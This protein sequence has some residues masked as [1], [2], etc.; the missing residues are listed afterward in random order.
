MRRLAKTSSQTRENLAKAV[1]EQAIEQIPRRCARVKTIVGEQGPRRGLILA[2]DQVQADFIAVGADG[3]G[4]AP[5]AGERDA[6]ITPFNAAGPCRAPPRRATNRAA[7]R[8]LW[9]IDDVPVV[10][11]PIDFL[12]GLA[13]PHGEAAR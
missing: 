9:A 13:W 5:V 8:V 7:Y 11:S 2:A 4:I 1:L 3:L 10:H 6:Q 12:Q